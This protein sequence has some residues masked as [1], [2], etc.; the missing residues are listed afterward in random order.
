M[1]AVEFET[2]IDNGI[3]HIP[4]HYKALQNSKKAKIIVMVDEP[5][6]EKDESVFAQ[7]L[8]NSRKVAKLTVFNRD[9]QHER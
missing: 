3:V 9:E 8:K 6:E 7:F 2:R 4:E 1:Y 5:T